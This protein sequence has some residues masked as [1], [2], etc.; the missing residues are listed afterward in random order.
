MR[1]EMANTIPIV[2]IH[3]GQSWYLPY[4][5]NQAKKA[6]PES[7]IVLLV[8]NAFVEGALNIDSEPFGQKKGAVSFSKVY[9]HMSP[10][11]YQ[12]ELFCFLRWFYLLEYMREYEVNK[13][14][15]L[16]SDCLLYSSA[17]TIVSWIG[18]YSCALSVPLQDF[19]SLD[20]CVSGHVS[21]WTK[22]SLELF[23]DFAIRT[24][25]DDA[26]LRL[27]EKKWKEDRRGGICDM[28]ALYLFH[29]ENESMIF[30]VAAEK[31][32][33][34]CDH[35]INGS[36]NYFDN[37]YQTMLGTKRIVFDHGTPFFLYRTTGKK[38]KAHNLHCQGSAKIL[39]PLYYRGEYFK[40]KKQHDS[41][42]FVKILWNNII[43]ISKFF[44]RPLKRR[45]IKLLGKA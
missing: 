9:K 6:S 44:L 36:S 39:I 34:V 27:Y 5:V 31:D 35:S 14:L 7:P 16:D 25:T 12:Y 37:E 2:F 3:N 32:G 41:S 42:S 21:F 23:C 26:Y 11:S 45:M 22:E 43:F 24:Y 20:W 10:N 13:V 29:R 28:T 40:G 1:K 33:A 8:Q 4:V 38:V 19:D 17:S 15:Y 30:N 18:D